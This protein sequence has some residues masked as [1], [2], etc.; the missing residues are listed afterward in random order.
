MRL[1]S[2]NQTMQTRKHDDDDDDN[3]HGELKEYKIATMIV[4]KLKTEVTMAMMTTRLQF[5]YR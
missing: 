1:K 5:G 4:R 2:Q 3:D